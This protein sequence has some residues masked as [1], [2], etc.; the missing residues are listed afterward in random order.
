MNIVE[1]PV[2]FQHRMCRD[3]PLRVRFS[4]IRF[5]SV[6]QMIDVPILSPGEG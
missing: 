4:F 1:I 6:L 3:A 2:H 5:G